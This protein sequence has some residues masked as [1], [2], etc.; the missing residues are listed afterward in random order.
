M[1]VSGNKKG[2]LPAACIVAGNGIGSG[3]MAIPYY[4]SHAGIAGAAA[5]FAAAYI[6]SV[7]MHFMIAHMAVKTGDHTGVLDIFNRY[8]FRGRPG[9][10]LRIVFFVLLVVVLTA[11]LAAYISGASE[12][13]TELLPVGSVIVKIVFF[14]CAALVVLAGLGAVCTSETVSMALMGFILLFMVGFSLLN[15]KEVISIPLSGG[16]AEWA[17]AYGMIMFSFSAIF[18][19]PQVVDYL[20]SKTEQT[21]KGISGKAPGGVRTAIW[22]G[23]LFNLIISVTVA[24]CTVIT[25]SEVTGIA[26][27]G[28]AEA[29]G[30]TIRILG[31]VF[32]VFAMLTSFWS[33][34]LASAD[35]V[36]GQTHL[37]REPSF[38]IATVPALILTLTVSSG[39]TDYLKLVGGIVAIIISLMA[40]PS[41]LICMKEEPGEGIMKYEGSKAVAA[42]L[43]IMY[44]IMAVGSCISV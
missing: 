27:V 28:W 33:I 26:I 35:I 9:S 22:L 23:L 14:L 31:S 16:I 18:A 42:F 25:S 37:G 3:V 43:F 6:V 19:V 17:A 20:G 10:A 34:G 30:G 12:I 11:N 24:V 29:V 8:L 41:F 36:A 38:V 40:V 39:F 15:T 1:A 7:L 44:V 13:F 2:I 4:V 32:I 21:D 5:A